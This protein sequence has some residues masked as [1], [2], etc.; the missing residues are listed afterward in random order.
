MTLSS[1]I[2]R[3]FDEFEELSPL[4]VLQS[5]KRFAQTN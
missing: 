2:N 5:L 3:P 1:P 4:T